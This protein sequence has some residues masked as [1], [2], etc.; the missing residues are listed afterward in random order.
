MRLAETGEDR[1]EFT[2]FELIVT[3]NAVDEVYGIRL[4]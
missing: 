4:S 1:D 3:L 2:Q